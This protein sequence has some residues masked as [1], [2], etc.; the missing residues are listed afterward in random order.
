M[1]CCNSLRYY[2]R[3]SINAIIQMFEEQQSNWTAHTLRFPLS[4][5]ICLCLIDAFIF[6]DEKCPDANEKKKSTNCELNIINLFTNPRC[7][8]THVKITIKTS[9]IQHK[10]KFSSTKYTILASDNIPLFSEH[11]HITGF[12][13]RSA[14]GEMKDVH[15]GSL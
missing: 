9:A 1:H 14:M 8:M 12:S 3:S 11:G 13:D 10:S 7:I 2:C 5:I 4:P 15:R 6:K